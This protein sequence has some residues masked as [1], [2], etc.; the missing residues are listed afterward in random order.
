MDD[1]KKIRSISVWIFIIPMV[2]VNICLFI[3]QSGGFAFSLAISEFVEP[4]GKIRPTFPYIDGGT[5]ISRIAR[6][7][8][9]YLIFKP[10]MILAG[11]LLIYYWF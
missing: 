8:P 4:L 2:A 9:T 3:A 1:I 5:S 10:A 6:F 11:I 7:F